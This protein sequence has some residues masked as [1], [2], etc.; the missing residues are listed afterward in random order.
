MDTGIKK[1]TDQLSEIKDM[2]S[3]FS[4]PLDIFAQLIDMGKNEHNMSD[5]EKTDKN[6]R[7]INIFR[8]YFEYDCKVN[9]DDYESL[10]GAW[11]KPFI[12]YI[13]HH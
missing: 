4:D 12:H 7:L 5:N 3:M 1:N 2:F 6:R 11:Q 10:I 8:L 9:P 13:G